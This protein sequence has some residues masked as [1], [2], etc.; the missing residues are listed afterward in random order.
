MAGD[1]GAACRPGIVHYVLHWARQYEPLVNRLEH[2]LAKLHNLPF[3]E[4][5]P[6]EDLPETPRSALDD[7]GYDAPQPP[8]RH[9]EDFPWRSTASPT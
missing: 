4:P 7:E 8:A 1:G 9:R 5:V 6:L 2:E 3:T